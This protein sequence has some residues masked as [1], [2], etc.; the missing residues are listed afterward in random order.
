MILN[1]KQLQVEPVL[2]RTSD[3]LDTI[4]DLKRQLAERPEEGIPI[5][6]GR[7]ELDAHDQQP[8]S[9]QSLC[10]QRTTTRNRHVEADSGG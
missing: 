9:L 10:V 4:A 1:E 2:L 6:H 5:I 7:A 3:L 8:S